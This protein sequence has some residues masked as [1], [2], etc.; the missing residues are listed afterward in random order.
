MSERIILIPERIDPMSKRII[1]MP[2][3]VA[4]EIGT[5][6]SDAGMGCFRIRKESFRCRNGLLPNSERI[7][8]TPEWVASD[9]GKN[10]SDTGIGCVD[11]GKIFPTPAVKLA[12]CY[13]A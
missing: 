2:E 7:I 12:E 9:V 8:P 10:H 13:L 6:H 5:N 3:W 1:P 11:V 4:S